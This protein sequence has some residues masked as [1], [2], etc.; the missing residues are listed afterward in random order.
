MEGDRRGFGGMEGL[1]GV[2]E[3]WIGGMEEGL[4][5][6]GGMEEAWDGDGSG[7]D[8]SWVWVVE[9]C[10]LE[11]RWCSW[12]MVSIYLGV[13][14]TVLDTWCDLIPCCV[15]HLCLMISC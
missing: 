11:W 6:W 15:V 3:G 2:G 13:G 1:E 7:W 8:I 12:E 5:G 9:L 4:G 10:V 14:V